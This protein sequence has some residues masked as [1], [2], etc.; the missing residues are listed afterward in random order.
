MQALFPA[1]CYGWLVGYF[2]R[3]RGRRAWDGAIVYS[4]IIVYIHT[5]CNNQ[6]TSYMVNFQTLDRGPALVA[7]A[8]PRFLKFKERFGFLYSTSDSALEF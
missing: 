4:G 3:S 2:G 5:H 7:V 6:R 1:L 8:K